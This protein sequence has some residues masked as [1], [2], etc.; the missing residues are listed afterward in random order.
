MM[1]VCYYKQINPYFAKP[2]VVSGT[3]DWRQDRNGGK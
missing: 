1:P 3:H 2:S